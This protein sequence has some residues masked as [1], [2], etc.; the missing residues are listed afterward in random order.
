MWSQGSFKPYPRVTGMKFHLN[1]DYLQMRLL[2]SRFV[3]FQ[4][5]FFRIKVFLSKFFFVC[6]M[7]FLRSIPPQVRP[8]LITEFDMFLMNPR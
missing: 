7:R 8:L 5:I 3:H 2:L 6:A 1:H 4:L